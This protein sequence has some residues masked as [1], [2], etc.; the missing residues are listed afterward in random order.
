MMSNDKALPMDIT[1]SRVF[2]APRETLF[3]AFAD[4]ENLAH[5]WGPDGFTNTIHTFDFRPGGTWHFTM[6]ASNGADFVN[7]STFTEISA[8]ERIVFIHHLP[9][10]VFTMTMTF[11]MEG[12]DTRLT[13][14][15]HFEPSADN[16]ALKDFIAAANEQNFDRLEAFL[17]HS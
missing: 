16:A 5:W 3:D 10:H 7:T 15:M 1:N 17:K 9:V 6:H 2:N 4:P 11:A 14:H 8:P 12:A 13:W